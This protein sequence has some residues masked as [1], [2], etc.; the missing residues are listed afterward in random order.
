MSGEKPNQVEGGGADSNSTRKPLSDASMSYES[1]D[2]FI[3]KIKGNT[4]DEGKFVLRRR[5]IGWKL[6]EIIIPL[7]K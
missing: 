4:G 3:V 1:M 7:E 6:T 2:K 5:G